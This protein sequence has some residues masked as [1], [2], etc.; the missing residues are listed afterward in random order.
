[1]K[2]FL[3]LICLMT[4]ATAFAATSEPYSM[5]GWNKDFQPA[6]ERYNSGGEL[7]RIQ[8]HCQSL[9]TIFLGLRKVCVE[10]SARLLF[11]AGHDRQRNISAAQTKLLLS[12]YNAPL[13]QYLVSHHY[14]DTLAFHTISGADI[15][16]KFH[17][18][19]CPKR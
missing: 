8:G 14:M 2:Y 10:R 11:H 17:Y 19:E 9:C 6:F 4:S 3:A 13:R 5:G 7:F 18:K 16:D 12:Y 15:I 1:M